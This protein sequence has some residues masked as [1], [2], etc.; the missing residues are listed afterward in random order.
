M[1]LKFTSLVL[2]VATPVLAAWPEYFAAV[3]ASQELQKKNLVSVTQTATYR[4]VGCYGFE[5]KYFFE[6]EMHTMHVQTIKNL[7][8]GEISVTFKG[9]SGMESD[10]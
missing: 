4:C 3:L 6:S 9:D 7:D 8:T 5:V 1:K 10:F 2:I